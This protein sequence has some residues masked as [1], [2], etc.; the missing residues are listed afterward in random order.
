MK[1]TARAFRSR[2]PLLIGTSIV[3][4]SL[5]SMAWAESP[6][7]VAKAPKPEPTAPQANVPADPHAACS[8]TV[9]VPAVPVA[10]AGM[11]ASIDP[12]TGMIGGMPP[13]AETPAQQADPVFEPVVLPDGSVMVDLKGTGQ[14]Y[15]ILELDANGNQVVRCIQDP[16]TA[17]SAAPVTPKRE[18]R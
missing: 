2:L 18:D 9:T 17:T 5:V 12:E 3:A 10:D 13:A 14:E 11:R 4:L 16:K 8:H 15:F 7:A 1:R 6:T